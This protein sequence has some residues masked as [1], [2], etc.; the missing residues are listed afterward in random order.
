MS[1]NINLSNGS[2]ELSLPSQQALSLSIHSSHLLQ[3]YLA[4]SSS[5]RV[6]SLLLHELSIAFLLTRGEIFYSL[7]KYF[8]C[9]RKL[10]AFFYLTIMIFLNI[11]TI[12]R[13]IVRIVAI[14][15]DKSFVLSN[16]NQLTSALSNIQLRLTTCLV[17]LLVYIKFN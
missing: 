9:V 7:T 16:Q 14:L 12:R 8:H 11:Y 17:F 3:Q 6:S 15:F 13:L 1:I 5:I 4:S 10:F 2:N